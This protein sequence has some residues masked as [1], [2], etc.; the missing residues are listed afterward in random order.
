[1]KKPL[2][3]GYAFVCC[4]VYVAESIGTYDSIAL[5]QRCVEDI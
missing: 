2:L 1:M 5:T 4:K 3:K